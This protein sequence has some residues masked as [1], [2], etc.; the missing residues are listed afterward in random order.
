MVAALVVLALLVARALL[1]PTAG[2]RARAGGLALALAPVVLGAHVWDT[3]AVAG[4]RDRPALLAAAAVAGLAAVAALAAL[5]ARRPA[6]FPLAAVAA[7]PF[8]VPIEVGGSTANL[9]VPLYAVVGAGVLAWIWPRL[10][11][12]A[13]DDDAPRAGNLER[14]LAAVLV[15]YAAGAAWSSDV[16]K[17]VEN[18]VF[19]YVPFALL[20]VLLA[21]I[22]WTPRLA[23]ACLGVLTVLALVF[24]G[25]GFGE[26]ATRTL[27]LNPKVIA[28]N[29]FEDYFRVN[30]L[31]FDPNIY[32]RF[33][34]VVMLALCGVL[35]W[36]RAPRAVVGAGLA[37]AIL[38]GGLV[39]TFS[40]SSFAGLLLGLAVLGALRWGTRRALAVAGAMVAVGAAVVLLAPGLINLQL[41]GS[42]D[43]DSAT[44]GRYDLVAG[45]VALAGDRPLLGHGSGAFA[46]E[47]RRAEDASAQKATSASH[48]TPITVAAEQGVVG[49]VAYLALVALAL[50]R[51]GRD[52]RASLPRMVVLAAFCAL[53]LHTMLYAAFLEDPLT[54]TLL[55]VGTALAPGAGTSAP[56]P[57]RAADG[58]GRRRSRRVR[59]TA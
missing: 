14:A 55:G 5:F 33:L 4:L 54:W 23:A 46:R 30:S 37:L 21:R 42:D 22:A 8:R 25:I 11:G 32:G 28:S 19:F 38:W 47:Y 40:Q 34:M 15:L 6:A 44:S 57:A 49:L 39:L 20:F 56:R 12:P 2:G 7:L 9:L 29:Q 26:Y 48:T 50:R 58:P 43:L 41:S 24:A 27:L 3:P 45:G 53:L 31:F 59:A 36:A 18:A 52:A 13:A 16:D 35:L 1:A 10:R 51:L 17:A